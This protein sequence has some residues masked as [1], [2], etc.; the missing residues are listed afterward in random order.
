M[1]TKYRE[2]PVEVEAMQFD[3]TDESAR[4]IIAWAEPDDP[5]HT[6]F[7]PW[8]GPDGSLLIETL[9]G[10]MAAPPGRWIIK[11]VQGELYPCKP[12]IFEA[13]YEAVETNEK[14]S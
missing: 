10:V 14:E 8:D 13:T 6:A 12:D 4:A 1:A 3:G 7:L 11:G 2:K 9:E 5:D